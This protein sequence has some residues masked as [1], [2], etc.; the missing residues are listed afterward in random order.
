M[1]SVLHTSYK[2]FYAFELSKVTRL[3]MKW[4]DTKHAKDYFCHEI[5]MLPRNRVSY[6]AYQRLR[7]V[8]ICLGSFEE[9]QIQ[10]SN[11]FFGFQAFREALP[12]AERL[13]SD[14]STLENWL[15]EKTS[16]VKRREEAGFPEDVDAE[17]KWNKVSLVHGYILCV[18][19]R[20]SWRFK[21]SRYLSA[22]EL[23]HSLTRETTA[24]N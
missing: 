22:K 20:V 12:L 17:I 3:T 4:R 13:E 15:D 16:D 7:L 18:L 1:R 24:V 9:E 11:N 14:M 19:C 8:K 23:T 6:H 2:G 21:A 10:S 5:N